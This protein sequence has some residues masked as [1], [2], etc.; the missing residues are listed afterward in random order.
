[1]PK[2]RAAG[3]GVTDLDADVREARILSAED[4]VMSSAGQD[5]EDASD[6][7]DAEPM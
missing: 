3:H 2:L 1:M 6:N 4:A 5:S 7:E